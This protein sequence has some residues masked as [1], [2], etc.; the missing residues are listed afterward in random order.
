MLKDVKGVG[1]KT[2][3]LLN[4]LGIFTIDDLL[5][6]YPFKYNSIAPTELRKGNVVIC[7]I[8]ETMPV[9]TYIKRN[10]NKLTFRI[11]ACDQLDR[12]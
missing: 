3:G 9:T 5:D 8:V 11:E 1:P 7:G 2:L 6:Y 12:S 4:K 10:L